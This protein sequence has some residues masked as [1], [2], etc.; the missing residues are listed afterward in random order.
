M[1]EADRKRFEKI[2]AEMEERK[3]HLIPN[4]HADWHTVRAREQRLR[5]LAYGWKRLARLQAAYIQGLET[6]PSLDDII[7]SAKP[8]R[9]KTGAARAD[10]PCEKCYR[11]T[12]HTR[13]SASWYRCGTCSVL[14]KGWA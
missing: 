1:N 2:H 6:L 9:G 10:M 3:K 11:V 8:E 7:T 14:T 12:R 13:V 4:K 5:A